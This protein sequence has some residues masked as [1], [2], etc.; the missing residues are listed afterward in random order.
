MLYIVVQGIKTFKIFLDYCYIIVLVFALYVSVKGLLFFF[1]VFIPKDYLLNNCITGHNENISYLI[2]YNFALMPVLFGFVILLA[3]LAQ[4]RNKL[5]IIFVNMLLV[6][7]SLQILISGSKRG[8]FIL[9]S[10]FLFLVVLFLSRRF[11]TL[12]LLR[13]LSKNIIYYFAF[14]FLLFFSFLL[15]I[16]LPYYT[17]NRILEIIGSKNVLITKAKIARLVL[18]YEVLFDNSI[19]NENVYQRLWSPVFNPLDPDSSWGSRIHKSVFPLFGKDSNVVPQDAI[20]YKLDWSC[21]ANYYKESNFSEAFSLLVNLTTNETD[22]VNSSV[23]CYV[24]EDFDGT[25]VF[26][27]VGTFGIPYANGKLIDYY[28][29]NEKGK[30]KKLCI[31]F[32]AKKGNVPL[33][34]SML[35]NG[36]KDFSGLKGY[37]IF[38]YP[39]FSIKDNKTSIINKKIAKDSSNKHSLIYASNLFSLGVL[40]MRTNDPLRKW[41]SDLQTE[42]TIFYKMIRISPSNCLD[43]YFNDDRLQRWKF[44]FNIFN[45]EYNLNQKITGTGFNFLNW[46][47]YY[48]LHDKTASDWPH[49]PFLSILLYSGI[50]GL[51][52]Y[53]FFLYKVFY[54]YIKYIKEYPL[55]FIFFLITFFFA[56]FS[57]GSPFDPPV[58]GFFS[59]LP[60]F[61]HSVHKRDEVK[62]VSQN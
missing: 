2:D 45:N 28:D 23:Y 11:I 53:C 41:M 44:A 39:N 51:L 33:Y 9:I 50:M 58:F 38:A 7:F 52:I 30:W 62:K 16:K 49:N 24:S 4:S 19:N 35:K 43:S 40:N 34:I 32:V 48:F 12:P 60:F 31:N 47:G 55:F 46:Y 61:I 17:K 42:D 26:L 21:D 57:S 13:L 10:I 1:D 56:F 37:V 18:R 25:S 29:L 54:Y 36:V 8:V 6:V 15:I 59:I 3:Y 5:T 22:S 14:I 20:G 27:T